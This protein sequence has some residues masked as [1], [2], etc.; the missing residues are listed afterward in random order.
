MVFIFKCVLYAKF[1]PLMSCFTVNFALDQLA[2]VAIHY[3]KF[4]VLVKLMGHLVAEG[5]NHSLNVSFL[6]IDVQ[7]A[8]D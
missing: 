1:K 6:S 2:L 5:L 8:V 7:M 3:N 4:F